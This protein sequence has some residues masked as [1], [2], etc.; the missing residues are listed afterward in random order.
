MITAAKTDRETSA[1]RGNIAPLSAS[2]SSMVDLGPALLST[3]L[4]ARWNVRRHVS[5]T[6]RLIPSAAVILKRDGTDERV[7]IG[8][9]RWKFSTPSAAEFDKDLSQCDQ[10]GVDTISGQVASQNVCI[11]SCDFHEVSGRGSQLPRENIKPHRSHA[12]V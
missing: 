11:T 6:L 1:R 4:L 2:R 10:S 12:C 9:P 8:F 3:S 5:R 7:P